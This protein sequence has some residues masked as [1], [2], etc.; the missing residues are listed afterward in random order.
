MPQ[1]TTDSDDNGLDHLRYELEVQKLEFEKEKEGNR[2]KIENQ[3]LLQAKK[4]TKIRF[5]SSFLLTTIVT[6]GL[7]LFGRYYEHRMSDRKSVV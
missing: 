3:N 4:E 5:L 1:K 6:V 7:A 2:V